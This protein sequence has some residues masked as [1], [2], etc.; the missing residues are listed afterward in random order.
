MGVA[1]VVGVSYRLRDLSLTLGHVT[2]NPNS[3]PNVGVAGYVT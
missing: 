2:T 3:N 1:G